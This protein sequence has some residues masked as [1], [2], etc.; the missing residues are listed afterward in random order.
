MIE[1]PKAPREPKRA[2]RACVVRTAGEEAA[3]AELT[4]TPTRTMPIRKLARM[5]LAADDAK[6]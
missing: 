2:E 3:R 5:R 1:R 4:P 6:L